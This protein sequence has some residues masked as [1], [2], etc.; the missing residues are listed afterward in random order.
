VHL[1]GGR[2]ELHGECRVST[3]VGIVESSAGVVEL[4]LEEDGLRIHAGERGARFLDGSGAR[5]IAP[6]A[7]L[8]IATPAL[9][10]A[11]R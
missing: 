8:A 2:L 9:P 6:G 3:A 5:E 1:Y 10:A 4:R 7:E 11:G